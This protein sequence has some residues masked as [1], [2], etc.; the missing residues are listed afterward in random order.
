MQELVIFFYVLA[1]GF[2][3]ALY[4]FRDKV[5]RVRVD[6][7][8]ELKIMMATRADFWFNNSDDFMVIMGA[9]DYESALTKKGL[10]AYREVMSL[11]IKLEAGRI[12]C[13]GSK[14]G[15]TNRY[16]EIVIPKE[17]P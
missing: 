9:K 6:Y 5:K 7:R 12:P 3:V 16:V 8:E 17:Q 15:G 11:I 4:M 2:L 14:G 1:V 10:S 13:N